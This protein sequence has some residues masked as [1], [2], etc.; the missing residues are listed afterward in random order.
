MTPIGFA[1]YNKQ[2]DVCKL[3]INK[4]AQH[5]LFNWIIAVGLNCLNGHSTEEHNA[6]LNM[7]EDKNQL[8]IKSAFKRILELQLLNDKKTWAGISQLNQFYQNNP[9][10]KKLIEQ[11]AKIFLSNKLKNNTLNELQICFSNEGWL[12]Y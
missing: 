1:I 10:M 4:N 6:V 8:P 5:C 3:L 2:W 12:W 7:M 9:K 11:S